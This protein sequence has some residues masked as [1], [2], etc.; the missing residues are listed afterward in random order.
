MGLEV[1]YEEIHQRIFK[2]KKFQFL[3]S[4]LDSLFLNNDIYISPEVSG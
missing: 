4:I 2:T 3:D 1:V